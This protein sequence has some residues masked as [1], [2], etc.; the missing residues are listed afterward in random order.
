STRSVN[1]MPRLLVALF[2]VALMASAGRVLVAQPTRAEVI[3]Q[4]QPYDGASVEGVDRTTLTGKVMAGYQGWFTAEGDGAG[5]GWRHYSKRGQFRP[6]S[7]NIDLW[8]DVSELDEDE[9]FATPFK[10]ADGQTAY[11]F[12]SHQRKT[13]LRHFRWM[14]E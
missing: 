13:V 3:A 4:M 9:K 5:A 10:H 2:A 7:C 1:I 11:V 6:G 8:P 14:Q 12:S